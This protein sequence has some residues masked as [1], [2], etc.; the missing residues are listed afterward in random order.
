MVYIRYYWLASMISNNE[1][2]PY[3]MN[4]IMTNINKNIAYVVAA[5]IFVLPVFAMASS[6]ASLNG[7]ATEAITIVVPTID[8]GDSGAVT[9]P[10]TNGSDSTATTP[11]ST[12]GSDSTAT[13]PPGSTGSD[14]STGPATPT[15]TPAPSNG[16]GS[17]GSTASSGSTGGSYGSGGS[18]ATNS[19]CPLL[20][21]YMKIGWEN[22]STEVVK[23]QSFLKNTEKLDVAV[24]GTFDAQTE[25]AV[26]SFQTKYADTIMTPWGVTTPTGVVFI[27]TMKKINQIACNTPLVLTSDELSAINSYKSQGNNVAVVSNEP[28]NTNT[29]SSSTSN[30]TLDTGTVVGTVSS[31]SNTAAAGNSWI[32]A[33]F[34]NFIKHLFARR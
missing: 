8:E 11:P 7:N 18:R 22:D 32:G 3:Y 1:K 19:F 13:T 16:G 26:K 5:A 34:W 31:T 21:T 15:Q 14:S 20:T 23:L 33:R 29:D 30:G 12:S 4:N 17:S 28:A 6:Q 24:T 9:T 25:T 10:G 2:S 27:T